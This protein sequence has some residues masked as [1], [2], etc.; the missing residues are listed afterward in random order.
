MNAKKEK[1]I[2][3]TNVLYIIKNDRKKLFIYILV[4]AF[5]AALLSYLW[6]KEYRAY[7]TVLPEKQSNLNFGSLSGLAGLAGIDIGAVQNQTTISPEL[8]YNIITGYSF[9]E[10]LLK[11][12]VKLPSEK[13]SILL[14]DYFENYQRS[15]PISK[16]YRL[17][18]E[19]LKLL[20]GKGV[21]A[22]QDDSNPFIKLSY[23]E[24]EMIER[25]KERI[26]FNYDKI[27]GIS[28]LSAITQNPYISA[29][30]LHNV[31]EQLKDYVLK[32]ETEKQKE[33]VEFIGQQVLKAEERY[34]E[35]QMKLASFRDENRYISTEKL[36]T[37]EQILNSEFTL[38]F[39][40]YST[41]SQQYEQSKIKLQELKPNITT[42]EPILIP[43]RKDT[44]K[45]KLIVVVT[46]FLVI[47]VRVIYLIYK[48]YNN[49]V[50]VD[51]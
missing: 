22:T 1:V 8:Y 10:S 38:A 23:D 25:L 36:K 16:I 6:P 33:N 2:S 49:V 50:V 40:L 29:Q 5:L 31:V 17:P 47:L 34:F 42:V 45:R 12:K 18:F 4:F 19:L 41:L 28:Y 3:L 27:N 30:L 13:D 24:Y 26:S 7:A 15:N 51:N 44:P 21:S 48:N 35:T 37:Q 43:I 11:K 32:Y 9:N 20:R 46:A 39:N 14:K